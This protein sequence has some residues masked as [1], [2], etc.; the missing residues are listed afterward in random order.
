MVTR[1]TP[2]TREAGAARGG[3]A[4]LLGG[5]GRRR[6]PQHALGQRVVE[7]GLGFLVRD[8]EGGGDLDTRLMR[9]R[10]YIVRSAADSAASRL[11]AA[12]FRTTSATWY[13]SPDFSFS[14][15]F[16]NRRDQLDGTAGRLGQH[17]DQVIEL[18]GARPAGA[19]PLPRPLSTGTDS[20]ISP[21]TDRRM[22]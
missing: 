10:S 9:A 20:F 4:L 18:L 1:S 7:V 15:W 11:R 19:H 14:W 22:R 3:S 12:R 17:G 5:A 21:I 16:L 8:V 6:R 13:T 2:H